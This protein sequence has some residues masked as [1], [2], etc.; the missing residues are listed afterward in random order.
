MGHVVT[1]NL[2]D[3]FKGL[4]TEPKLNERAAYFLKLAKHAS[5]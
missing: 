2:F 4:N 3:I 5:M 1:N